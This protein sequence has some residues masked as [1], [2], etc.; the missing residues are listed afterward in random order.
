M[1]STK[2]MEELISMVLIIGTLLSAAFVI[3]G[4]TLYLLQNGSENVHTELLQNNAYPTSIKQIW[5]IALSFSPL[6]MIEL[7]LLLL[8]ATQILRVGLLAWFYAYIRDYRFTC[9]SLFILLMLLYS[10]VL[11]N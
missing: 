2:K 6:G 3:I 11:R 8:V 1:F 5:I 10:F 7:G 4:G 9:M